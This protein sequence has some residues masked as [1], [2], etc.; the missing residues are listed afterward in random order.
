HAY[1]VHFRNSN[2]DCKVSG[3]MQTS[4]YVN[5]FLGNDPKLWA[6]HVNKYKVVN[7]QELYKKID[8]KIY[9][10]GTLLKYDLIVNPGGNLNKVELEYEGVD[11][12]SVTQDG[13][14]LIK[15]SVCQIME[16]RPYAFQVSGADTIPVDCN[17]KLKGTRLV[18]ETGKY[19]K[20]L[21]LIIDPTLV[22]STYSGS[23]TDNWGF[24]ATFDSDGNVFSGGIVTGTGYPTSTGAFQVNFGG[25]EAY[26]PT[27]YQFGWDA[28]IIK[29]SANGTQR[30]WA[31][32]LGGNSSD[33]PHSLVVNEFD[34]LIIFGTTGSSDFP[35]STLAYDR[36]FNGGTTVAY[37]NVIKFS[38]GVDIYVTRVSYDGSLII[39]STYIGGS[40][41]DGF[42]YRASYDAFLMTGNDSLYYNYA[43]GARGEVICDDQNNIYVG[44]T[45]FSNNFPVSNGFQSSSGGLQDG[46]VF[47]LDQ[48]LSN[49]IWSSYIGG[50]FDDAVYSIDVDSNYDLYV[51][52]GTASS[53]FPTRPGAYQSNYLGK[54]DGFVSHIS[55]YGS[56]LMQSTFFGSTNYDQSYFVR[57]DRNNKVYI[58]GQTKAPGSALIFNAL[59]S[60][61]NSGQF[62]AEFVPNLSSLVW[63]TVFGTGSGK[64]NISPTAFSVDICNRMY[65]SGSGRE[66]PYSPNTWA[67]IEGTKNMVTTPGAYQTTTDG[68]DFYIMVI[69]D[70][71]STLEYATFFGEA[72]SSGCGMDHVDGGTSR[73]DKR[74]NIY[75]SVCASCGG[76]DAFPTTPGAWS[77]TNNDN[78]LNNCNNAV[79]KFQI[80][81][82]FSLAD[83]DMP[84]V[85]CAPC[86][87]QFDNNSVGTNF[88]WDFGDSSPTS[89]DQNPSHTYTQSGTYTVTLIVSDPSSCNIADTVTNEIQIL[90][91]SSSTIPDANVCFGN[92]EQIG[93][94]PNSDT[95]IHYSW[96]PPGGL[97]ATNIPNP[98]AQPDSTTTYML[99]ISGGVCNDTIYQ[100]VNIFS[101]D[102]SANDMMVCLGQASTITAAASGS[103][104]TFIW[105]SSPSFSDTLNADIYNPDL[106]ITGLA[107]AV[108]YVT[109]KDGYCEV[110]D[111]VVV[112]VDMFDAAP[113][114]IAHPL[115]FGYCTGSAEVI[116]QYGVGS[117]VY[118]W[119]QGDQT[120]A[121]DSLC[122]DTY[123]VTLH[124]SLQCVKILSVIIENP[125]ELIA[126]FLDSSNTACNGLC[127]G[128]ATLTA[129]GGTP[130]Y[131][132]LWG[133][134][135]T[136]PSATGL[137]GGF[138]YVTVTDDNGCTDTARVFISDESDLYVTRLFTNIRCNSECNGTASVTAFLGE[139]PYQYSW[140]TGDTTAS[141]S[142]LCPGSYN[143]KITDSD[144]CVRMEFFTITQPPA[145]VLDVDSIKD[146]S[147]YNYCDGVAIAL[148]SGGTGNLTY[149][150]S[151]GALSATATGLCAGEYYV[152]V[153]DANTCLEIDTVVL[154]QPT[155]LLATTAQTITACLGACNGSASVDATGSVPPYTYAWSNGSSGSTVS[156]LCPG[157]YAISVTDANTCIATD[158]ATILHGDYVPPVTATYSP[159]SVYQGQSVILQAIPDSY[160]GYNWYPPEQVE[161]PTSPI[162]KATPQTSGEFIV[163][164]VDNLGCSNS[165]TVFIHVVE[166]ICGDPYIFLP[167]A[168]TPNGD[169]KNDV[170]Y[171]RGSVIEELYFAIYDRWGEKVFETTD[172]SI[173]WDGTFRGKDVDPGVFD[174]YIK[175]G[176]YNKKE[177]FEKGNITV[178]R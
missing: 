14:L 174:Y 160:A 32:Y 38:N 106:D 58:Y 53:N 110:T 8:L 79:F 88:L 119:S 108:Y 76:C 145:I 177:Y 121:V 98:Y 89:S 35:T 175:A 167:N 47:K 11:A 133:D 124:D 30:L 153:T 155:Q 92:S 51:T 74:G 173:G 127:E 80:M 4:D 96:T 42:N 131:S 70:D 129:F 23:Y 87:V 111:S 13:G 41:N 9:S 146:V 36:T 120:Q 102:L 161:S 63:S 48:S 81:Y 72:S 18:F 20:D 78:T 5:Y 40:A 123:T 117:I 142:G 62:L 114:N 66:W 21:P 99:I 139:P 33:M 94:P 170:F 54:V 71:A 26:S 178:I 29:Y 97:S 28:G 22:F 134:G 140:N 95:S 55:R 135:Q 25:G 176:C 125:D 6:S 104:P 138:N 128:A 150:W 10:D 49:L 171:V 34:E 2:A 83:F 56:Q 152:S 52:G 31:S 165:D 68:Q 82:D 163:T 154:V 65:L 101:F 59:Y 46:V 45:T 141:I 116:P 37:D 164:V 73:F 77:N 84:P 132:Y 44:T 15:T 27:W 64:P 17:Y 69:R 107:D 103:N 130:N 162:T 122:A 19:D 100:T 85:G 137:C 67:S 169:N 157:V 75:Q 24:T 1:K 118:Q 43:D 60:N 172:K 149:V 12:I 136:T 7:Y 168:F 50:S 57:T 90:S 91:N 3:E 39:G 93:L 166:Y 112:I 147:C 109:A 16:L 105:S 151:S 86:T 143:V 126:A 115:C 61:P 156:G 113:G 144:S 148:A 158:T 159:D